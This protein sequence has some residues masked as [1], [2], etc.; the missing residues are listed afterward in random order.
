[1]KNNSKDHKNENAFESSKELRI[2]DSLHSRN[3]RSPLSA[4]KDYIQQYFDLTQKLG[5]IFESI[6]GVESIESANQFPFTTVF[7]IAEMILLSITKSIYLLLETMKPDYS[8]EYLPCHCTNVAFLSCKVGVEL[9]LTYNE[10]LELCVAALLHDIGMVNLVNKSY[11]Q[12]QTLS[13]EERY[14]IEE[15]PIIGWNFFKTLEDQ[16]PWLLKVILEE[17]KRE[18]NQGYPQWVKG[19][20]HIYSKIVGICDTF[21]SLSHERIFRKAFH[22]VDAMKKT[23][24]G[25]KGLFEKKI[26]KALIEAMSIYPIGSLVQL[27]NSEIVQVIQ[28]TKSAPVKPVVC[29]LEERKNR[30][31]HTS[32]VID[33]SQDNTRYITNVVYLDSYKTPKKE[34]E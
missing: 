22:P 3:E 5:K 13:E 6:R 7:S 17:H 28:S 33:L 25:G 12:K 18:N 29:I 11:L 30:M 27:N 16:F 19:E 9:G 10:L 20:L 1:M 15:H 2:L 23:I 24:E 32:Q 4:G 31:V 14:K 26:L 34:G 8:D 21:E